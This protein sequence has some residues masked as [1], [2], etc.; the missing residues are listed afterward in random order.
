MH[1]VIDE[2]E[3]ANLVVQLARVVS[4]ALYFT[5]LRFY[6][7]MLYRFPCCCRT[8]LDRSSSPT[9]VNIL[10]VPTSLLELRRGFA[11]PCCS[12]YLAGEMCTCATLDNNAVPLQLMMMLLAPLQLQKVPL[13]V[14]NL[15]LLLLVLMNQIWVLESL[16]PQMMLLGTLQYQSILLVQHLQ[17][18]KVNLCT[19]KCY[20]TCWNQCSNFKLLIIVC[21]Y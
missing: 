7:G 6:V 13:E 16:Q 12:F 10:L 11:L 19:L 5:I 18:V 2:R 15:F 3:Q 14:L 9:M 21:T 8:L 17:P 1:G 20:D 4:V